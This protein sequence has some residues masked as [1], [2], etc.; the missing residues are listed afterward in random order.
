MENKNAIIISDIL[1][2]FTYRIN[3]ETDND[4]MIHR[5]KI[6]KI[7]NKLIN[8]AISKEEVVEE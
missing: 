8:D 7:K 6:T 2:R 4:G 3:Q 1:D 5:S